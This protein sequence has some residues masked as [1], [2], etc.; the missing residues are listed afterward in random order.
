MAENWTL[1]RQGSRT[2]VLLL[3]IEDVRDAERYVRQENDALRR[4]AHD[5]YGNDDVMSQK[6][7]ED[8]ALTSLLIPVSRRTDSLPTMTELMELRRAARRD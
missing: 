6:Y 5:L 4:E 2:P 8:N 3:V 7:Y 1:V